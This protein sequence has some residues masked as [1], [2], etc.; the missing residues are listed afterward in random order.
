[1]DIIKRIED[2]LKLQY[3]N[4][5]DLIP[6][7]LSAWWKNIFSNQ[8][9]KLIND[10]LSLNKDTLNNFRR[11]LRFVLDLPMGRQYFNL[12]NLIDGERRSHSRMLK[13][14]MHLL[15]ERGY[16]GLLK[17][18][19][20]LRIGNPFMYKYK[21]CLFTLRWAMQIYYLGLFKSI[22][23]DKLKEKFIALDL[24][25]S[26]GIFSYLLKKE[27]PH[28]C[29]ILV[30]LPQQLATAHYFL[31]M[32]FPHARIATYKD[33]MDME[34][35][36]E[37]FLRRYDFILL[38]CRLYHK[39]SSGSVDV[40]TNFFSLGEMSREY[41]DYYLTNGPFF[42]AKFFFTINRYQ[43]AP[44]YDNGLT[45]LDYPLGGFNKVHFATTPLGAKRYRRK[46]IFFSEFH[47]YSSQFFEFIGG[48]KDAK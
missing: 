15:E 47:P 17:K 8:T 36:E 21:K 26:Y 32:S 19:P 9:A 11:R 48:K 35:I 10:D 22:L 4:R 39:I 44:T 14:I 38:P 6:D 30:D 34:R 31:A 20:S 13:S 29:H 3:R 40:L 16:D 12:R 23:A 1:M 25:S 5:S 42:S 43:S 45:I 33:I 24:G 28:S 27:F 18:Y 41:F 7:D 46:F 37:D 2:D